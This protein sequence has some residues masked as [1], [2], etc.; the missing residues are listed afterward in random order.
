VPAPTSCTFSFEVLSSGSTSLV[1]ID[2]PVN[3]VFPLVIDSAVA[4]QYRLSC[5]IGEGIVDLC[6]WTPDVYYF[7]VPPVI[8]PSR[9]VVMDKHRVTSIGGSTV[10]S[11]RLKEDVYVEE[12]YNTSLT[13]TAPNTLTIAAQIGAGKG[14]S[15]DILPI[16]RTV[17]DGIIS[18]NQVLPD[19]LGNINIADGRGI[20]L[21]NTAPGV[22]TVTTT[23][24]DNRIMCNS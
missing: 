4:E 14:V 22:I 18:I 12:G 13:L 20:K 16:A 24:D 23:I 6:T 1:W 7:N 9:I 15:C 17:A 10:A 21:T 19:S 3:S 5:T 11:I 2:V 8:L